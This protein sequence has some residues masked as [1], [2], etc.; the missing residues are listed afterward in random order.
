ML[1][2]YTYVKV[3]WCYPIGSSR[4]DLFLS[5]CSRYFSLCPVYLLIFKFKY[6]FFCHSIWLLSPPSEFL[7]Q[8]SNLGVLSSFP[9]LFEHILFNFTEYSSNNPF[10]TLPVSSN[11]W[12]I[13]GFLSVWFFAS[14]GWV[15]L[16][17]GWFVCMWVDFS[18][19]GHLKC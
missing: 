5:L 3:V 8:I 15:P 1:F 10:K 17:W 16:S 6:S 19:P 11:I 13:S 4:F 9:F 12:V 7:F 2:S 14:G 18:H